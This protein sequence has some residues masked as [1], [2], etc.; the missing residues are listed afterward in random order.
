MKDKKIRQIAFYGKGGVGKSTTASNTA[1]ALAEEGYR[2]M[3]IGCDPKHDC[4]GN[5]RGGK[6]ITTALDIL[7]DKGLE[8]RTLEE[9]IT[10]KI[11]KPEEVI[12][13]GYRG[14]ACVEAGGP[15]PGYGCAGRGVIVVIELLQKIGAFEAIRPDVVIYDVLGDVVCGGFAMPL[16]LGLA[17]E[18]Y[19]VTSA[20]YLSLYA[21]NNICRG[22]AELGRRGGSPLGG[23]VYNVRG[24]LDEPEII[25]DFARRIDSQVVGKVPN[26][27][28]IA[29]AE[30]EGRTVV[31][32]APQSSIARLYRNLARTIYLNE[33]RVIPQP[34]SNE[35]LV[36]VGQEIKN[37]LRENYWRQEK[38]RTREKT[39]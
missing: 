21:A 38:V 27:Q 17:E 20:D 24:T 33:T 1:A 25:N 19:I 29:A 37:R 14:I 2:V 28:L 5:L 4:T 39:I 15:K 9:M 18:I 26:N 23:I 32:Y 35:E 16:R 6:E 12:F 10:G 8:K 11:I 30:I 22:V 36:A 7:R 13:S 31:E 3:M 34:L